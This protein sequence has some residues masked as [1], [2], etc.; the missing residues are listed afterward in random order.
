MDDITSSCKA[1][2][3]LT[4]QKNPCAIQG[5]FF[6]NLEQNLLKQSFFGW[7]YTLQANIDGGLTTVMPLVLKGFIH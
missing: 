5:F 1:E 7:F 4:Y 6:V 2:V 3:I